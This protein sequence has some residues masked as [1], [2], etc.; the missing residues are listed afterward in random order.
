MA[1]EWPEATAAAEAEQPCPFCPR[2][3]VEQ[4]INLVAAVAALHI[5]AT[6]KPEKA[7]MAVRMAAAAVV[8]IR[9][10]GRLISAT[11]APAERL[12][13]MVG[14]AGRQETG[15]FLP[16]PPQCSSHM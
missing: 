9:I 2:E 8:E 12:A 4:A 16:S 7:G 6:K 10:V 5:T 11:V 13:E 3:Q 15:P 1:A 14:P